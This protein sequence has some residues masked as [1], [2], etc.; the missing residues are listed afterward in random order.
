M[1]TV[2]ILIIISASCVVL[3]ILFRDDSRKK[4]NLFAVIQA[5]EQVESGGDCNAV[6]DS[7][8]A[9]GCL[10]IWKIYV[11][12]VNRISGKH[13]TYADR[14]SREKSYEMT[15]IYLLHYAAEKRLNRKPT[16]EDYAR[17]HNAGPNGYKKPCS[18]QYGLKVRKLISH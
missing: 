1:K 8:R 14:Y 17:I 6:G 15:E 11:D 9:V 13:F 18:V 2:A 5:I 12:D 16:I 3:I 7:G 10:Q 4:I